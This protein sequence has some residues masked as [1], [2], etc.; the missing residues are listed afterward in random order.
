MAITLP[1]IWIDVT[2]LVD[3]TGPPTG[4]QRV[5]YEFAI[6]LRST[7][8]TRSQCCRFDPSSARYLSISDEVLTPRTSSSNS[9][10]SSRPSPLPNDSEASTPAQ[11]LAK[12]FAIRIARKAKPY[13]VAA[14][15]VSGSTEAQVP[16]ESR[17]IFTAG[18]HLIVLGANWLTPGYADTL[19]SV[20]TQF[21]LALTQIVYDLIPSL[22]PQW[23]ATGAASIV[24]PFLRTVLPLSTNIVAISHNTAS[25]IRRFCE[26]ENVEIPNAT[27]GV[28]HL[29]ADATPA[30]LDTP[31]PRQIDPT[32]PYILCVGT[33]EVRKNQFVLYQAYREAHRRGVT[34]PKLLIVGRPGWLAETT[35]HAIRHDPIVAESITVLA[36]IGDH[37][38]QWLYDHC[39][40]TVYPSLYEGWGLPV[41]ESLQRAKVCL[42]TDQA[43]IPEIGRDLADY[44]SP[45]DP[46]A[47][48]EGILKYCDATTR[49]TREQAIRSDYRLRTW[50]S[51]FT[52]FLS[53]VGLA[54]TR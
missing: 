16:R 6:R 12:Q 25:D 15:K 7:F 53:T 54:P 8:P 41:A 50:D 31:P 18:D 4:I 5:G 32:I 28:V 21:A 44:I 19:A 43:S 17:E 27:L 1:N 33:L 24:T 39:L 2:D 45:F 14:R 46:R 10:P 20:T 22:H 40:F 36:G 34:L 26:L 29:G 23:A 11:Q 49:K 38:L 48:L 52:D 42:T 47:W 9:Q 30:A 13:V 51:A 3:W 37:E 35:Q